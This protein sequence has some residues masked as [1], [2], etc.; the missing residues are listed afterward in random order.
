[1]LRNRGYEV[2]P[3]LGI[4]GFF[5]D[6]TVRNPDRP[7]EF[8]AAVE[9]DGATYHSSHSARDR[10]RIRQTILESLG[11]KDRIWRIWSTDWFYDPRRESERL[12]AFLE[13][14]RA[15]V[16]SEPVLDYDI[17][18]V[19]EEMEEADQTTTAD[20][21]DTTIDPTLLI[22]EEELYVEVGDRVIYCFV[23]KPEERH[24][25]MIVDTESNSRLNL[26]NENAPLAKALL[27]LAVG[28]EPELE[29][30]GTPTRVIRI[31]R[32]HRADG[33]AFNFADNSLQRTR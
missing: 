2:V 12:L 30:K 33:Q 14:R 26:I 31:L 29:V 6:L 19:P 23:D 13:E 11:W 5:I 32:I 20:V 22:S 17:E 3:Q 18:D 10:D 16:S 27:N 4:A 9:C 24:S 15:L 8:L 7:G 1:M 25:V 28:D 21:A